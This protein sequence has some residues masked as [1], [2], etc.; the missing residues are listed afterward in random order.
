MA[1]AISNFFDLAFWLL[2]LPAIWK[3][4]VFGKLPVWLQICLFTAMG[5]SGVSGIIAGL[6]S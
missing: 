6:Q 3:Y 2:M 4:N 5:V 1:L